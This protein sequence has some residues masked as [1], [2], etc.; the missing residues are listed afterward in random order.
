MWNELFGRENAAGMEIRLNS[1]RFMVV[2]TLAAKGESWHNPDDKI[3]VPLTTAQERLF[4]TDS[5]TRI[6]AQMRQAEDFGEA[7][8][9][10]ETLLRR[11]HRLRPDAE[12]D[13]RVWRQGSYLAA[14]QDTNREIAQLI[15]VI[16]LVSLLVGALGIANV[17]LVSVT[18]RTPEIGI[19]RSLGATRYHVLVQFLT[20]AVVLGITGG[21]LGVLGGATFNQLYLGADAT[22]PKL[23]PPLSALD[24][25]SC[26]SRWWHRLHPFARNEAYRPQVCRPPLAGGSRNRPR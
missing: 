21:L 5:L 16:A 3:F 26:R 6:L 15:I 9:D 8:F 19:R 7:L 11:S 10:I 24:A 4:G 14:I 23:R 1:Q 25:T 20:E 2:G 13:F 22:L 18:E 17:M 12:N